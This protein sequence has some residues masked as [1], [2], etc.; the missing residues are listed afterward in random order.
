[1]ITRVLLL[2]IDNIVFKVNIITENQKDALNHLTEENLL[3]QRYTAPV[4][5][6]SQDASLFETL[7]QMQMN[8]IKHIVITAKTKPIGIVTEHDINKFLENDKTTRTFDEIPINHVMKKNPMTLQDGLDDHFHKCAARMKTFDIGSIVLVNDNGDLIGIVTKTDIARIFSV[9]YG[10]KYNV[11]DYMSKNVMTCRKS[12]SLRFALDMINKNK[13]SRLVVTDNDGNPLGL[14]TTNT[15][16]RHSN[17]F[18]KGRTR[19]RDYLLPIESDHNLSVGDLVSKDLLTSNLDND[20]ASAASLMT[21]NMISGIPVIDNNRKLVGVI[22]NSD[23]VSA[24][25]DVDI[26]NGLKTKEKEFPQKGN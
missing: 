11:K 10:G 14:I 23:I 6:V 5:T 2:K 7:Q 25:Y 3:M 12:D 21:K 16:L 13:I 15:F 19:S 22:T 8:F 9:I 1:M 17:Y 24:F 26:H 4:I 20:L 18:T